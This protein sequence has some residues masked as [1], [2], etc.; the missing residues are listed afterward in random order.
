MATTYLSKDYTTNPTNGAIANFSVWVKRGNLGARNKIIGAYDGGAAGQ[1]LEF[2]TN[3]TIRY[4]SGN[5]LNTTNAVFRDTSAWY[6]IVVL[7]NTGG[8]GASNQVKI[9]VNGNLQSLST[10]SGATV[11]SQ[12]GKNSVKTVIGVEESAYSSSYFDGSMS[13]FHF[14]DGTAYDATA[15]GEYDA[16]GVWKIK[17]SPSVT[18]GTNG[19]F[20][21]KDGNSVTDQS[22]NGNNFTVAGGTLTNTEDCPSNVFA[23]QNPLQYIGAGCNLTFEHGNNTVSND[24]SVGNVSTLGASSGKYYWEGKLVSFVNGNSGTG[25]NVYEIGVNGSVFGTNN[26]FSGSGNSYG[27]SYQGTGNKRNSATASSFGN[28]YTT[29]DIIGIAMDLDNNKLYFSKNGVWQNSGDP[30]SGATG[31]GAAFTLT[32]PSSTNAGFYFACCGHQDNNAKWSMNFGNGYF[33]TTAVSSA[34]TNA[35][36]IG[37]FE[38]DVPTGYTALSTKGLNL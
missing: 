21:L 31:T 8:S 27:Y 6:H 37:I 32:A 16:N 12:I 10:N 2:F 17:T 13:H 24:C 36:G 3:N 30:T 18:Y 22:G 14:I 26:G 7:H 25:P 9:W 1:Y 15:F 33:G 28:T 35:S 20:I 11:N 34:G 5:G 29:N 19:F 23:T 38:Y 4:H